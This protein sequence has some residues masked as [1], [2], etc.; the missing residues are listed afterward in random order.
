MPQPKSPPTVMCSNGTAGGVVSPWSTIPQL[1]ERSGSSMFHQHS[2]APPGRRPQPCVKDSLVS[3]KP[4]V[5]TDGQL[6]S[7]SPPAAIPHDEPSGPTAAT[8]ALGVASLDALLP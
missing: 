4:P 2:A 6:Q 5:G 8:G 7:S 1:S 3:A